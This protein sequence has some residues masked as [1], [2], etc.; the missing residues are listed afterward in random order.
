MVRFYDPKDENDLARVEELL[1]RNGIEYSLAPDSGQWPVEIRVA[2][3]DIPQ[4]EMLLQK[5]ASN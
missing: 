5:A 4:A 3:E 1:R 2:E